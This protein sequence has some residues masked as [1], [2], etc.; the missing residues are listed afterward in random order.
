MI[1]FPK[2]AILYIYRTQYGRHTLSEVIY[3]MRRN[4]IAI[5]LVFV[6][7]F[8]FASC[9]QLEKTDMFVVESKAYIVDDSGVTRNVQTRVNEAGETEYYYLDSLGNVITVGKNDV[10]VETKRVLASTTDSYTFSPEAQS[11]I[12]TFNDPTALDE[13]IDT[14]I[15]QPSLSI[16]DGLIPDSG[17]KDIEPV[18]EPDGTPLREQFNKDFKEV[19]ASE[20]FTLGLTVEFEVDGEKTR[21]PITM[22]RNGTDMCIETNMPV[23]GK[24]ALKVSFIIKDTKLYLVIPAMRCYLEVPEDFLTNIFPE[25]ILN[26]EMTADT[27]KYSSSG[28]VT[29]NG[30][31]YTCDIYETEGGVAKY[32]FDSKG[33]LKRIESIPESGSATIIEINEIKKS[34][35]KSKIKVPSGY[36]DMTKIMGE[37]FDLSSLA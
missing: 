27:S 9:K 6:L 5:L 19:V 28:E 13:L 15:T 16:T 12:D 11:F 7:A 36:F 23:E 34:V 8:G 31:K 37:N 2:W 3:Y 29:V 4:I 1:L 21:L 32:Y 17:M 18:T 24:G 10:V 33:D 26:G 30:E 20:K 35:D 25:D 22:Y 14:E